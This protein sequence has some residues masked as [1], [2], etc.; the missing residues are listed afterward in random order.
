MIFVLVGELTIPT[1]QTLAGFTEDGE[2]LVLVKGTGGFLLG[3]GYFGKRFSRL[4]RLDGSDGMVP[5][6]LD[7]L[8]RSDALSTEVFFARVAPRRRQIVVVATLSKE[9]KKKSRNFK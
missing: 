6:D 9:G 3:G 8:M 4:R 1:S 7:S 5:G 2:K